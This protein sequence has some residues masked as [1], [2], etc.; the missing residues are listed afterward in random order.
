MRNRIILFATMLFT[1]AFYPARHLKSLT[2]WQPL[3]VLPAIRLLVKAEL[4]E[5]NNG[6][7]LGVYS[8]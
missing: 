2:D 7:L 4:Y 8:V 3:R 1:I 5:L 6:F